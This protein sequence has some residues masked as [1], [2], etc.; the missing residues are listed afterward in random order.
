MSALEFPGILIKNTGAQT[1][2]SDSHSV[3]EI[4]TQVSGYWPLVILTQYHETTLWETRNTSLKIYNENKEH[5]G[6]LN[7]VKETFKNSFTVLKC[8]LLGC[9][10]HHFKNIFWKPPRNKNF[11]KKK[12]NLIK[13]DIVH[14]S[15]TPKYA[16]RRWPRAKVAHFHYFLNVEDAAKSKENIIFC[17]HWNR[18]FSWSPN[19]YKET[20]QITHDYTT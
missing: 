2:P 6:F 19:S 5:S 18:I 8:I 20:V 7:T 4:G 12:T 15:L 10:N 9:Q 16:F 11:F 13:N 14:R 3:S 1:H 17:N